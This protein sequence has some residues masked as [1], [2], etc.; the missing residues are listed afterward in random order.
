MERAR[1]RAIRSD[2]LW[3]RVPLDPEHLV[4]VA[5]IP[6]RN[7]R[8]P[9]C[10]MGLMRRRAR[11]CRSARGRRARSRRRLAEVG[12]CSPPPPTVSVPTV[13]VTPRRRHRSRFHCRC[14]RASRCRR[15][16]RRRRR[17][18]PRAA[19]AVEPPAAVAPAV[20]PPSTRLGLRSTTQSPAGGAAVGAL[21]TCSDEPAAGQPSARAAQPA[22]GVK[23]APRPSLTRCD[24]PAPEGAGFFGPIG[25]ALTLD[26]PAEAIRRFS[27]RWPHWRSCSSLWPRRRY[28]R[29][30]RDHGRHAR[31][32]AR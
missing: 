13:T 20:P 18:P 6:L 32:H 19:P 31:P 21:P 9:I 7:D 30:P 3:I 4:V 11:F 24:G 14:R 10:V 2:R 5:F 28:P 17:R 8:G 12:H 26:I 16:S 23:G 15:R 27:S 25:S 22:S 1:T 29:E